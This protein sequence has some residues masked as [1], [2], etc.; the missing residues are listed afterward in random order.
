MDAQNLPNT[1]AILAVLLDMRIP[2][3]LSMRDCEV[4]SSII[5]EEVEKIKV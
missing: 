3:T 1:D 5:K 2:L 4:I